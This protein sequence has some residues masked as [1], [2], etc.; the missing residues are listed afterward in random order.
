MTKLK[1]DAVKFH[2]KS[3]GQFFFNMIQSIV[4]SKTNKLWK[5][6]KILY[7]KLKREKK[8]RDNEQYIESSSEGIFS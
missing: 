3:M 6:L 4:E 8:N 7:K 1:I 2:K 5:Q